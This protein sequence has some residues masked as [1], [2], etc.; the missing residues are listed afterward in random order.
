MT[1]KK[2]NK[3]DFRLGFPEVIYITREKDSVDT[4]LIPREDFKDIGD[5]EVVGVYSLTRAKK[6][7]T[8][9]EL[10]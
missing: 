1:T 6:V 10:V 7:K 2:I 9:V 8:S 4:Y 3:N 5:G